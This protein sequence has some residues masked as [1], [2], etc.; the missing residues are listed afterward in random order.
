M[1]VTAKRA[2]KRGTRLRTKIAAMGQ[3]AART[4]LVM[5]IAQAM[6]LELYLQASPIP[7]SSSAG[8]HETTP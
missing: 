1:I 3:R 6:L 7:L 8:Y 5:L 2:V 4:V